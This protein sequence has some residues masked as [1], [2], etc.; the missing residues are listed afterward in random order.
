MLVSVVG[1][2]CE[3]GA[4]VKSVGL[5]HFG[6]VGYRQQGGLYGLVA[7]LLDSCPFWILSVSIRPCDYYCMDLLFDSLPSV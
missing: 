3:D 5:N 1:S 4:V 2:R 7:G 6:P